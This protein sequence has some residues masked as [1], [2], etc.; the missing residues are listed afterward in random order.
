MTGDVPEDA[1]R[2]LNRLNPA[3]MMLLAELHADGGELEDSDIRNRFQGNA[4][5]DA[6]FSDVLDDL[7]GDGRIEI[8]GD[9]VALTDQ[10]ARTAASLHGRLRQTKGAVSDSP[11]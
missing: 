6:G 11:E 10:G 1:E 7:A 9:A 3:E 4:D 2:K 8:D 5:A